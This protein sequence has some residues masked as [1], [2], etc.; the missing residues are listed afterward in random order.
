VFRKKYHPEAKAYVGTP[1][2]ISDYAPAFLKIEMKGKAPV[3]ETDTLGNFK[4]NG[5]T[6]TYQ[7]ISIRYDMA[8]LAMEAAGRPFELPKEYKVV[9][10]PSSSFGTVAKICY[11]E[12]KKVRVSARIPQEYTDF[13]A[14]G[15]SSL[16][17]MILAGLKA[18]SG[19]K[20]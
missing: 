5:F 8:A 3:V 19:G 18:V 14:C 9:E 15:F 7:T 2:E 4:I 16:S 1:T 17:E 11:A 12:N 10:T 6:V 20:V 13:A